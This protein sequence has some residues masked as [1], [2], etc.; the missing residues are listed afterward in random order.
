MSASPVCFLSHSELEKSKYEKDGKENKH[1]LRSDYVA[2]GSHNYSQG[3][4]NVRFTGRD[5]DAQEAT[6][7]VAQL[8]GRC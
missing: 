6:Q 3:G 1:Q 2:D 8:R 5:R 4:S 7:R